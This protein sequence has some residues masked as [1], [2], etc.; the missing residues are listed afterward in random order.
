M[1][2]QVDCVMIDHRDGKYHLPIATKFVNAGIPVFIDKP[3]ST[4]LS[5]AKRFLAL[6]KK[7]KIAVTT[8]SAMPHQKSFLELSS[9]ID[10]LEGVSTISMHGSGDYK[11]HYGGLFFYAIHQVDMMISIM[12]KLPVKVLTTVNGESCTTICLYPDN[13]TV[14]ITLSPDINCFYV[15]VIGKSSSIHK[16]IETDK[17]VY[18]TTTKMFTHMFTTGVEPYDDSRMLMPI[19]VLEAMSESFKKSQWIKVVKL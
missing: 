12:K 6:R 11:S 3:L 14:T 19:A 13:K 2:S 15:T 18:S 1:I 7:K 4:S 10:D 9:A 8:L 17:D 16:K 5:E